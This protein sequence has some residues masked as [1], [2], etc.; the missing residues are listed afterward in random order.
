MTII[1]LIEIPLQGNKVMENQTE[2]TFF[3]SSS[4][5]AK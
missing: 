5:L 4:I 1:L 2:D 3:D